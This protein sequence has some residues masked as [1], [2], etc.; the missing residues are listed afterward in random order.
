MQRTR[1]PHCFH[2]ISL[3]S[4]RIDSVTSF[5]IYLQITRGARSRFVLFRTRNIP[6]AKQTIQ[7]MLDNGVERLF[8]LTE[9]KR[10]YHRYLERNLK[11]ILRDESVAVE[12][13]SKMAYTCATGLVEE[14]LEHPR[15]GEHIRRSK[16]MIANLADYLFSG[17]QTFFSL[18]ATTSFD[19][20]TY[21]HSVN[22][23]IFGM[24]LAQKL[25]VYTRQQIQTIGAGL[26]VHDIGKSA[27]DKRILNKRG[28]LNSNEWSI[29]KQ[30]PE[31]GF[32]LLKDSRELSQEALT[33]VLDH[34]E[35]LDGSG[36]PRGLRGE[37]VHQYARIAALADIFDALTTRRPY[38]L[39]EKS[40][41]ALQIM[42]DE[43]ASGLDQ[44]LF[45][46]FVQ[47]FGPIESPSSPE[48]P[49]DFDF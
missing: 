28:R 19:Y 4:L 2:P 22:V 29:M 37:A 16:K 42:R 35:K 17:A 26:I 30:H 34:H 8:I 24:A 11:Y 7:S 14:L 18:I 32:R 9:D 33:V 1:D 38:K 27:I 41:P 46:E 13:K 47:L 40:F 48:K 5:D 23:A 20:Y 25:G 43:M 3:H 36:Y 39:A 6:I 31:N 44:E 15:S 10:E 49:P 45:K 21:T 12:E